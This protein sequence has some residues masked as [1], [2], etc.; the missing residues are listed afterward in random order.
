LS[1]EIRAGPDKNSKLATTQKSSGEEIATHQKQVIGSCEGARFFI[2][3]QPPMLSRVFLKSDGFWRNSH[4]KKTVFFPTQ[5][6]NQ[7]V[8]IRFRK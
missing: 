2:W 3:A 1:N 8:K 7:V 6:Q 5:L 4:Q